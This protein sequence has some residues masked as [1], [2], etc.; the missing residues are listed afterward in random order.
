MICISWIA[1]QEGFRRKYGALTSRPPFQKGCHRSTSRLF[2]ALSALLAL[3]YPAAQT[4]CRGVP[5]ATES[6]ALAAVVT[7]NSF[8]NE[9]LCFER[10]VIWKNSFEC[11]CDIFWR[12]IAALFL[13]PATS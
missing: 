3:V 7:V 1:F 5:I 8:F 2:A 9:R 6:S 13:E 10:H 4:I 12:S 11:A